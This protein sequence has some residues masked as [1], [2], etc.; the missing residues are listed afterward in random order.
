MTARVFEHKLVVKH[1]FY[2]PGAK[3]CFS[4]NK[5]MLKG[6]TLGGYV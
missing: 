3:G 4:E 5:I 1:G 2:A 6:E